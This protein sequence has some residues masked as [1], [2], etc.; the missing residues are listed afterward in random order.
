M[1]PL[2]WTVSPMIYCSLFPKIA[3]GF[4]HAHSNYYLFLF[5]FNRLFRVF[6]I[7]GLLCSSCV[8]DSLKV[9][10]E[11]KFILLSSLMI[12]IS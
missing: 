4:L 8:I 5:L 11:L 3:S 6:V 12:K 9:D 10:Y 7:S 2:I 1:G